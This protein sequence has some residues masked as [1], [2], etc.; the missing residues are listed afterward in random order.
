MPDY[1]VT[2]S[3]QVGGSSPTISQFLQ[4]TRRSLDE[5]SALTFQ[6]YRIIFGDVPL[7]ANTPSAP[8]GG[9]KPEDE[10][11][12]LSLMAA[13]LNPRIG[14]IHGKLVEIRERLR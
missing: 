2:G 3:Y 5:L 4:E 12:S 1:E 7:P 14:E 8:N 11:D 10:A 6:L 9:S 13:Q